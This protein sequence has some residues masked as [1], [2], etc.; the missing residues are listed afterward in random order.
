[1]EGTDWKIFSKTSIKDSVSQPK[2]ARGKIRK[3]I[4]VSLGLR[5]TEVSS[6]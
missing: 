1:V 5:V 4:P 6:F 3:E 2:A